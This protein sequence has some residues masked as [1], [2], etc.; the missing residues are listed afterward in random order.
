MTSRRPRRRRRTER[1][2]REWGAD[3]SFLFFFFP[4]V[5]VAA[6]ASPT[7]VATSPE[8]MDRRGNQRVRADNESPR[9]ARPLQNAR[10]TIGRHPERVPSK[11]I[12][13]GLREIRPFL[14]PTTYANVWVGRWAICCFFSTGQGA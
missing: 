5:L 14:P 8:N 4:F 1:V 13:G 7:A 6:S 12:Y 2:T 3:G 10:G 11:Q 9:D